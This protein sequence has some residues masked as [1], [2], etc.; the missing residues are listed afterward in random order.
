MP[1]YIVLCCLPG[2]TL[3]FKI[4]SQRHN[5][6]KNVTEHKMCILIFSAIFFWNISGSRKDLSR[7][8]ECTSVFI[9]SPRYSWHDLMKLECSQQII[10]KNQILIL[11]KNRPIRAELFHTDRQTDRQTDM[12]KLTVAFRNSTTWPKNST[13]LPEYVSSAAIA[14]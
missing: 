10:K 13:F 1:Y 2:S 8:H 12:M 11:M 5:F 9:W 14:I 3:F 4:I 7:Y 6:Q